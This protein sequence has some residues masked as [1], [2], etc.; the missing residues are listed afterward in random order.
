MKTPPKGRAGRVEKRAVKTMGKA[1]KTFS[2]AEAT[3]L[4]GGPKVKNF[5][6]DEWSNSEMKAD[7]LYRKSARQETR[8]KG[9]MEKSKFL[10]AKKA[11]S[12]PGMVGK[13]VKKGK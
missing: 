5:A 4:S 9:Q 10:A 3:R 2:K 1:Q 6:Q 11:K 8:A 12:T 7:Q 13:T